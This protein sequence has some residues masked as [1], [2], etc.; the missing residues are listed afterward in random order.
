MKLQVYVLSALMLSGCAANR[1]FIDAGSET[2][3]QAVPAT[4]AIKLQVG[5][6]EVVIR[7]VSGS[8]LN[9]HVELSCQQGD[10]G[11]GRRVEKVHFTSQA[12]TSAILISLE[13][14]SMYA[15]HDVQ[16][17]IDVS[18]PRDRP[19]RVQMGAGDLEITGMHNCVALDMYAGD[20]EIHIK[21][22]A[23][24][25]VSLDV[26]T[27]DTALVVDGKPLAGKRALLVGA[28]LDWH[29][30]DGWCQVLG[31]LQFGD[32]TVYLDSE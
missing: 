10:Q 19:L 7:G 5:A 24:G 4:A 18:V 31:D 13:P 22:S 29:D 17:R 26:G 11:C 15:W 23:V 21:E 20:A 27:G 2:I 32:L 9:A 14:S 12:D 30:G 16:A 8:E 3:R 28:E 6:G 1:E 25:S